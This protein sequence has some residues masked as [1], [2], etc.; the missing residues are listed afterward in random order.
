[1]ALSGM[2]K[3]LLFV[4]QFDI[5]KGKITLLGDREI[6]LHASAIL[7]LQEMDETKIYQAAKQSSLK[8]IAGAVEHAK[9]YGKMRDVFMD[10]IAALGNKI[11]QSDEGVINTLQE[12]FNIYGLGEINIQELNNNEKKALVVIRDS[13][14]VEE[15]TKKNKSRA[16]SGVCALT[17]GVIA[18]L[19]SYIFGREVDCIEEK[20]KAQGN[21]YCLFKVG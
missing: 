17:A 15:Y 10:E 4:R 12:I 8:N 16:K 5:D 20:C 14:L 19:F 21:S 3:K 6:M 9:V 2:L 1:M 7:E 13:A 18:G 11:G